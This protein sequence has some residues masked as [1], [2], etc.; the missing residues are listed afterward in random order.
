[1]Q[2]KEDYKGQRA[3][4]AQAARSSAHQVYRD[5][6]AAALGIYEDEKA[7]ISQSY[8]DELKRIAKQFRDVK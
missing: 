5:R 2:R 4:H 8:Q 6:M 3:A 1:M 7:R